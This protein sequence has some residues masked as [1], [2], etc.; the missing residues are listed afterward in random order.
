MMPLEIGLRPQDWYAQAARAY[1]QQHQGC[2]SCQRQH[3]VF[4]SVS[5][6][7]VEYYCS[8]CEF[9]V[10]HDRKTGACMATPGKP[11]AVSPTLIDIAL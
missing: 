3:C 1:L 5:G 9:A 7:R 4:R 8:V 10:C 2:P 11:D 6:S